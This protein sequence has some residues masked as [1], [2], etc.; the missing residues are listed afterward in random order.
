MFLLAKI[1][2]SD[3]YGVILA[4]TDLAEVSVY[5]INIALWLLS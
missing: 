1:E 2:F 5:E 4:K 3:R